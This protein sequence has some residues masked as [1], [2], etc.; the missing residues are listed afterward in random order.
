[1]Q[2][3]CR[4][5]PKSSGASIWWHVV[6]S[7]K[8]QRTLQGIIPAACA[9]CVFLVLPDN[10]WALQSHGPPEGLY[11]HQMAHVHFFLALGYLYW[12][13]RRSS[14][15]GKGWRYLLIFCLFMICW[16]VV[17][18]VGH[19]VAPHVDG[20]TISTVGGY[21]NSRII[22]PHTFH[23][24]IF[25]ITKLDHFVL[26]PALFFLFLGMRSLYRSVE[27]HAGEAGR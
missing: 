20:Q 3:F 17:A 24:I 2:K 26:V 8:I 16:N 14:F 25:Y 5:F 19:A 4:F 6:I 27:K 1:M 22:G 11:V 23:T 10:A 9:V 7:S 18:F 21:L 13:I 12:D 15:A